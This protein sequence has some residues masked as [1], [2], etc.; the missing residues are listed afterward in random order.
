[1]PDRQG[2]SQG[3]KRFKCVRQGFVKRGWSQIDRE[4]MGEIKENI[5]GKVGVRRSWSLKDRNARLFTTNL[6][7]RKCRMRK[8]LE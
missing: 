5:L 2:R 3:N 7:H 4:G 6:H 8:N 1:M